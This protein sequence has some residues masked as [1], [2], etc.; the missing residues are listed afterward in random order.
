MLVSA[1]THFYLSVWC[2][3]KRQNCTS[4]TN[5]IWGNFIYC[6]LTH[7]QTQ[8]SC[9]I[10]PQWRALG[11]PPHKHLHRWYVNRE[12]LSLGCPIVI[13]GP[14]G[15]PLDSYIN[16]T[17]TGSDI[18]CETLCVFKLL[19]TEKTHWQ[20]LSHSMGFQRINRHSLPV[21]RLLWE[22]CMCVFKY[23]IYYF[24]SEYVD[25]NCLF[26]LRSVR[27]T[28]IVF[29]GCVYVYQSFLKRSVVRIKQIMV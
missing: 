8:K 28:L 13:A 21:H 2:R 24:M 23:V 10:F 11:S 19:Q 12:E 5:N 4:Q 16:G 29:D 9:I 15:T 6:L 22:L 27:L 14:A 3:R 25:R 20:F 1:H 18:L 26:Y 17:A 7:Y